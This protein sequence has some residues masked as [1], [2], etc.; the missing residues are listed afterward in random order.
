MNTIKQLIKQK[1]DIIKKTKK[2]NRIMLTG[3]MGQLG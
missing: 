1:L 3:G 2:L